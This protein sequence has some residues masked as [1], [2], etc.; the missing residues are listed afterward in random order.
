MTEDRVSWSST[1]D[2][3]LTT[4]LARFYMNLDIFFALALSLAYVI[5]G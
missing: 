5:E 3:R 2:V 4:L 1:F